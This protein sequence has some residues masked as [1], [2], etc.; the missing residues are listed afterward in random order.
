M[1]KLISLLLAL[2]LVMGLAVPALA[3]EDDTFP[4]YIDIGQLAD[5]MK[6]VSGVWLYTYGGMTKVS[7]VQMTLVSGTVYSYLVPSGTTSGDVTV[8]YTDDTYVTAGFTY[9]T[10]STG[11][12]LYT[13]TSLSEGTWST[14]TQTEGDVT[15]N[16][17]PVIKI[18]DIVLSDYNGN[19]SVTVDEANKTYTVTVPADA[20]RV[21]ATVTV[22]GQN[23]D[24][25]TD[26][27][28]TVAFVKNVHTALTP[29]MYDAAT[30][31][32]SFRVYVRATDTGDAMQYSADGGMTW[33]KTDWSVVIRKEAV[34]YNVT[35]NAA[36]NGTVTA[37]SATAAEG[38]T[39]ELSVD[40]DEGYELDTLTVMQGETAVDV[41][42]DHTFVMPAGHVTVTATFKA[43]EKA[44]NITINESENGTVVAMVGEQQ[45]TS[46]HHS[47]DV[48]LVVTPADGYALD[49]LTVTNTATG[50]P[51]TVSENN[52][53]VMPE[54]DV[55]VTAVFVKVYTIEARAAYGNGTVTANMTTAAEGETVTVTFTPDAGYALFEQRAYDPNNPSDDVELTP[56]TEANTYTFQMPA[57]DVQVVGHIVKGGKA[58]NDLYF[59]N[60]GNTAWTDVSADFYTNTGHLIDSVSLTMAEGGIYTLPEGAVIPNL[61]YKV[62]FYNNADSTGSLDIPTD[63]NN[64]FTLGTTTNEYGQYEGTWS[65]Y[66]PS[67]PPVGV[68]SAEIVWGS[69]SFTYTDGEDGAEGAWSNDGTEGAGTVTVKNTGTTTFSA[70]PSYTA[71][72]DYDEI[73][74]RFYKSEE[75]ESPISM[76]Y[77]LASEESITFLL[78]L[79]N[80][81]EKAIPAGTKI[82]TVTITI[83]EGNAE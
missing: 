9:P 31:T 20:D 7:N 1:K 18:T 83:T 15:A 33:T 21:L 50:E 80:Q 82:G 77:P 67:Q 79:F 62:F 17:T 26:N 48:T 52:T 27:T 56:G 32:M 72:A 45:V 10:D 53:F 78:K 55:T 73:I 49:Q 5:S 68:T 12:N 39:V 13:P 54:S 44:Y 34:K 58:R 41:A 47:D 42:E 74:A 61:A 70:Q 28:Y 24:K 60:G 40:A 43:A 29:N 14:Y 66:T 65:V 64:M 4:L 57:F 22:K 25:I 69:L 63:D 6:E 23:L 30:G 46:A 81:P 37:S 2:A 36:E 76:G 71:V 11:K 75:P 38:E 59:D 51:V 19:G 3:A 35:V 16:Y 8:W